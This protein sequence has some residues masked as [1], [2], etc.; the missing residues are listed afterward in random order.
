MTSP[1]KKLLHSFIQAISIAPLQASPL[2]LRCAPNTAR[3]LEFHVEVPQATANEGLA[4][5]PYVA[6]RAEFKPATLQTKGT[7]STNE[8]PHPIGL[9]QCCP[10]RG[11]RAACGPPTDFM[12]PSSAG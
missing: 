3:M 1:S 5:V 2:L 4:Q 10:T 11:P 12:R 6:A 7:K 9:Q 8:P